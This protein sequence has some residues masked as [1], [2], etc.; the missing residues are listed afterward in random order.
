MVQYHNELCGVLPNQP[1]AGKLQYYV[2]LNKD[3]KS[4]FIAKEEP[5]VIRFRGDVPV[6]VVIPHV[7]LIFMAMFFST[8]SGL[9]VIFKRNNYGKYVKWAFFTLL[10]GGFVFGPLMQ[11]Y[12]FGEFWTGIPFGFD[13]TDNKT[14]F[15]FVFWL[16]A[17]LANRKKQRPVPV[18][19][20]CVMTIIIFSI[21]H[22]LMGSELDYSTNK[23]KTGMIIM[24]N[25]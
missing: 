19:I 12:A 1:P 3:G 25:L 13:L 7:L 4:Y 18:L 5:I 2:E 22:S 24:R 23:V 21:P 11:W 8:L 10:A 14:L 15:V 17:F 6:F 9:Y 20:A 16:W